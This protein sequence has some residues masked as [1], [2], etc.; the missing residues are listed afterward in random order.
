[1]CMEDLENGKEL[2]PRCPE[3]AK[4]PN[5]NLKTLILLNNRDGFEIH[6]QVLLQ[7]SNSLIN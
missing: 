2:W 1:M 5:C 3:C 4:K 6:V 7:M